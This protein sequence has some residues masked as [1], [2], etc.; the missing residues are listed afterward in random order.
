MWRPWPSAA[1]PRP[2]PVGLCR[3]TPPA[4]AAECQHGVRGARPRRRPGGA[5][6]RP[7]AASG[8]WVRIVPPTRP[9]QP[10]GKG[11]PENVHLVPIRVSDRR[12]GAVLLLQPAE[13]FES[14]DDRLAVARPRRRSAW[15]WNA[16]DCNNEATE[17]EILRR[18]DQLRTALLTPSRTICAPRSPRSLRPRAACANRTCAGRRTSGTAFAQAIEEEAEPP[19]PL[20]GNLLDMSRIEGG[21]LPTADRAGYDLGA[22]IDDVRRGG[23]A[24]V[25]AG[26]RVDVS[27]PDDLPPVLLDY[28]RDRPGALQPGRKRRQ[29]RAGRDRNRA[30]TVR[31]EGRSVAWSRWPTAGRASR[32]KRCRTCSSRSI[33]VD[34]RPARPQGLGSGLAIVK[35]LVEA[36]G[37]QVTGRESWRGWGAV[38]V[39]AAIGRHVDRAPVRLRCPAREPGFRRADPGRR[40][41]ARDCARRADRTWADTTFGS[42][43]LPRRRKV[44]ERYARFDPT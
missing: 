10:T 41:R 5:A 30:S 12:L 25:T 1:R 13:D 14:A 38:H 29:V 15:R 40:R 44:L 33:R 9:T 26:H 42:T 20:V 3:A 34:G 16:I 36:H 18:T 39:H 27:A 22:L 23:C 2:A 31:R 7:R 17:A 11:L 37:G 32:P 21:I 35:G 19:E 43:R 4:C 28:R 8:R 6:R 24:S